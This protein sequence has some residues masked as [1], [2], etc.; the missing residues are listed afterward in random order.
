MYLESKERDENQSRIMKLSEIL[1]NLKYSYDIAGRNYFDLF[2]DELETHNFDKDLLLRF[3]QDLPASPDVCDFGCGPAA[4]YAGF[5]SDYCGTTFAVDLSCECIK[6]AK[7]NN[8][9]IVFS[10]ENMLESSF[11]DSSLDGVI[12]F[13]SLFHIPKEFNDMFFSEAFRVLKPG[14]R[15]LLMTHKGDLRKTFTSLWNC[16][17]LEVY[18]NFHTEEELI[19]YSTSAGFIVEECFSKETYYSFPDERVILSAKKPAT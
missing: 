13:Y 15:L 11:E 10:C 19:E 4:Q 6:L 14:G 18:A 5:I 7:K 8:P 2:H 12:S 17:N 16:D 9:E 1:K 3:V